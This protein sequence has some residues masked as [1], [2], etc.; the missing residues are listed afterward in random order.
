MGAGVGIRAPARDAQEPPV[1]RRRPL[2]RFPCRAPQGASG[3]GKYKS[4][5]ASRAGTPSAARRYPERARPVDI[6]YVTNFAGA[7][8]VVR[9]GALTHRG[10]R[11]WIALALPLLALFALIGGLAVPVV[12]WRNAASSAHQQQL[13]IDSLNLQIERINALD[14]KVQALG[15]VGEDVL[16]QFGT[17]RGVGEYAASG[18]IDSPDIDA[19]DLPGL[20]EAYTGSVASEFQRIADGE[21]PAPAEHE[22]AYHAPGYAS[23]RATVAEV[24]RKARLVA[25]QRDHD[26]GVSTLGLLALVLLLATGGAV[27]AL[28][29]RRADLL[30]RLER[31]ALVASEERFR[32]LIQHSIDMILILDSTGRVTY[33][34]PGVA[35]T[36]GLD[37]QALV[38]SPLADVIDPQQ[39]PEFREHLARCAGQEGATELLEFRWMTPSGH[40]LEVEAT[41]QNQL[42]VAGVEGIVVT[43]RPVTERKRFEAQLVHLANHD[44]LTGLFNRRRFDEELRRALQRARATAG[45]GSIFF[46]DLDDFKAANDSLGHRVG[47]DFLRSIA[48]VLEVELDAVEV[49]A[50]FGGDE[51]AVL[52]PRTSDAAALAERLRLAVRRHRLIVESHELASTVSI[53][54]AVFP[55]HGANVDDLLTRADLAM[56]QAKENGD[57]WRVFDPMFD[58]QSDLTAHRLWSQR[59]RDALESDRLVLHAQPVQHLRTGSREYELL[60]RMVDEQGQMIPPAEFLGVAERS[61][62]I[63]EIDRWVL[64]QAVALL[65]R[66]AARGGELH[67]A[68]NISGRTLRDPSLAEFIERELR[69]AGVP[70]A[71]LALEV[72][73]TAAITDM[74]SA[75][76]FMRR[77]KSV[78]CRFAI[79]DFGA[80][81]ASFGYLKHLPID[82][83]K[84]DGSFIRNLPNTVS[85]QHFVRAMVE[86][87]RGLE[88]Q[89]VAEFVEDAETLALLTMMGVD[90][91]QGFHLAAPAPVAEV[92]EQYPPRRR[93]AA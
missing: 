13:L 3:T 24:S 90:Y 35:R 32:S 8:E 39:V 29:R 21:M 78:G 1:R 37:E 53:G 81:F 67:V 80:G 23:L 33:E 89:T 75:A 86:V 46:L 48:A 22:Q 47:D 27:F 20:F 6:H 84:I 74:E 16:S 12:G 45:G 54:V 61:G 87:A 62:L 2:G 77:L 59:I 92:L 66:E 44:P 71:S 30:A 88:V 17:Y 9:P 69:E 5:Q 79:D 76:E 4:C 55:E 11:S 10:R 38:D 51:F 41:L 85:D 58:Y 26:A 57:A 43:A 68:A 60:V 56:Y 70:A 14:W 73:E 72:T 64:R 19:E 49:L 15:F 65:A 63:A 82:Y 18:V 52:S 31:Q 93:R 34:S 25:E 40:W 91:A 7:G 28:R 42:G 83:V 50:R 36:M